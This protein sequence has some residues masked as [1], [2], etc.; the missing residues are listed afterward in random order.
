MRR[1][2]R[3]REA[4][5]GLY[6]PLYLSVQMRALRKASRQVRSVREFVRGLVDTAHPLL[7]HI[8]PMRRCNIDCGYCNEFDKVSKPVPLE[9]MKERVAKLASLGTSVVAFSG[10][11]PMLHPQ[12]DDIIR[13][14][15][16]HGMI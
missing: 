15:R 9:T 16:V 5:R 6:L 3:G 7:V 10:G 8:V 12:L 1:G 14:I 13:P 11:E 4:T 2:S